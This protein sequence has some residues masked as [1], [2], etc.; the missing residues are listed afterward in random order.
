MSGHSVLIVEDELLIRLALSE[1]L[2]D[3][4]FHILEAASAAEAMDIMERQKVELVFTDVR[5]PGDMDGVELARWVTKYWPGIPV[6]LT[7]GEMGGIKA[8]EELCQASH[9]SAFTKPYRYGEV[10]RK[11]REAIAASQRRA[12]EPA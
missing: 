6:M 11:M 1:Y 8:M 5:M 7:S 9:V 12:A 3:C 2:A 10:E 4:G